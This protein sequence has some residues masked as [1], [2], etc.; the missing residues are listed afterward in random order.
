MS[1]I[2]ALQGQIWYSLAVFEEDS[3]ALCV[4]ITSKTQISPSPFPITACR[5]DLLI[6]LQLFSS[7]GV[8]YSCL[9]KSSCL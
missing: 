8:V 4:L 1:V 9:Q 5:W 2:L 6:R 3:H 7:I